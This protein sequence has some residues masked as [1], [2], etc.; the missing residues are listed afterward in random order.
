M[1]AALDFGTPA[2]CPAL[3]VEALRA[4]FPIF[5]SNPGL[6][7]LDTAASAQKPR[8]VIDGVADY[9]RTDYANVHR[10]VYQLSERSSQRYD[11]ARVT[12]A[13]FLNAAESSEIVFVR[14]ATEAINLVAQTWG[15]GF[16]Q[17]GDE[18]LITGLEH[19]ANIVPWQML[20]D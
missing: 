10:G 15:L 6:V 20:R 1:S 7:F 17:P 13:G 11:A 5:A 9:Y 18:I 4:Q 16:L 2:A 8:E 14:G 12:V 19:H 3:D